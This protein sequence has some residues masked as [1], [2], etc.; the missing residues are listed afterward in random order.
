MNME[1]QANLFAVDLLCPPESVK[2]AVAEG[3]SIAELAD[4]FQV[5]ESVICEALKKSDK[6]GRELL[7]KYR[8]GFTHSELCKIAEKWL[9]NAGKCSVAIAEPNCII[10][11]EQPD[12][13]G[14]QSACSVLVEAK[15]SKADFASDA[16]KPFR[17][18][19]EKGMGDFRYYICQPGIIDICELPESWGLLHVLP[20]GRVRK[21]KPAQRQPQ[22]NLIEERRLLIACLRIRKPLKVRTVYGHSVLTI[23]EEASHAN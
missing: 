8:D 23:G 17:R 16:K 7:R 3:A 22:A 10:T 21:V 12:A 4:K 9:L 2:K 11:T 1:R 15:T 6:A 20:S 14:F 13:I 19:P 5:E 18:L